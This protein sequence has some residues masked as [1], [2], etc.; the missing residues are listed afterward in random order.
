M[1][2]H[3]AVDQLLNDVLLGEDPA[4]TAALADSTAAGLPPI[5]VTPQAAHFLGLLI[6]MCGAG[7]VLEIGTLG[8]YSTISLARAVGPE[9]RVVTLEFEPRHAE[10]AAANL[11]RAGVADRVEIVVGA[12]LET[13]PGLSGEFDFVFIDADKENNSAYVQWAIDL[14][15]P[16]TV[17]V[18]DNIIR[19]GRVL[20]PAADDLQATAVRAMLEMMGR[21]PRLDTAAI[22]TVGGKGWDGFALALVT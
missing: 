4:L 12:A 17:I 2:D 13:L 21:H 8:G 9:G 6:R 15:H 7:R 10:I 11:S 1:T 19:N 20:H 18:V 22:Q 14:G 5:E 16:G 3:A